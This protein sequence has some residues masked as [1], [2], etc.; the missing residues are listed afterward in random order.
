MRRIRFKT[1]AEYIRAQPRQTQ[2]VL[3]KVRAIIRQ[4][5][6]EADELI[7]YQIPAYKM[8]GYPVLFF[9]A[10]SEHYSLYPVSARLA[11]A[12][13]KDL[14]RH[15]VEKATIRFPWEGRV[16][17]GLITRIAKFRAREAAQ[18]LRIRPSSRARGAPARAPRAGRP[19]ASYRR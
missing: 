15:E 19:P 3:R 5:L 7:S 17:I 1:V 6:P 18:R 14:A 9:A 2:P 11:E 10:W 13:R 4:A 12:L 16:P 8:K